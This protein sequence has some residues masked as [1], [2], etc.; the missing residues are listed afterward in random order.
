MSHKT[1]RF[2]FDVGSSA[3]YNMLILWCRIIW[4]AGNRTRSTDWFLV[5]SGYSTDERN[6]LDKEMF[7]FVI[8][9]HILQ[10]CL[11]YRFRKP[12]T[13]KNLTSQTLK[14]VDLLSG[15][16][17]TVSSAV[18]WKRQSSQRGFSLDSD[19]RAF[20]FV[21]IFGCWMCK[22]HVP[23]GKKKSMYCHNVLK[24]LTFDTD[25]P[26]WFQNSESVFLEIDYIL[27]FFLLTTQTN[28]TLILEHPSNAFYSRGSS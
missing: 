25:E 27:L 21:C 14:N 8:H 20:V 1:K 11:F 4:K 26:N 10:T 17:F 28:F 18:S 6:I 15:P 9:A 24:I 3:K 19:L 12:K 22:H 23:N 16:P 13:N 5:G 2:L 7:Q